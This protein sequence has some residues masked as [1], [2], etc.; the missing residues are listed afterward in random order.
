ML[1]VLRTPPA[2]A[3]ERGTHMTYCVMLHY[4]TLSLLT[5]A[6]HNCHSLPQ[7]ATTVTPHHSMSQLSL[8]ATACHNCHSSPQ[9][10]T[11]VTPCHSMPQLSLLTTACHNCHSLP[12][13]ATTVT[14]HHSISQLS[15][16]TDNLHLPDPSDTPTLHTTQCTDDG[17]N[18]PFEFGYW[19]LICTWSQ[20][21]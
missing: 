14:P 13:H 2:V 17:H 20:K 9:H 4:T 12:Q 16:L 21:L 15:L 3:A 7:H 10:V 18:V 1:L 11:T 8:L 6:R 5:A 19:S